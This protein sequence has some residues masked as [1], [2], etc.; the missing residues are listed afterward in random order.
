MAETHHHSASLFLALSVGIGVAACQSVPPDPEATGDPALVVLLVVDQLGE[1]L[2]ERYEDVYTGG[3]RR[4]LDDGYRFTSATHDHASTET[5][6]GHATLATGV[7]PTRHGIVGNSWS[8]RDGDGWRSEYALEELGSPVLGLPDREGRGPENIEREGLANWVLERNG[9]GKVVSVSGKDRSA[10]AMA[11]TAPGQVYWLERDAGL[12]VTAEHYRSE[13]PD[14]VADFNANDIPA[15]YG[16]T[17]WT[18]EVPEALKARSRPDTSRYEERRDPAFPHALS[19]LA[20][21]SIPD[22]VN[23]WRWTFTPFTDRAVTSFAIRAIREEQLGRR[24]PQDYLGVSLSA[25]DLVG[26]RFGPGSREQLDNLLRLDRELE[27]LFDA[28]DD[29]VG[30]GR[31]VLVMS[32]DHGVLEI[33]EELSEAGQDAGRLG[34][35]ERGDFIAALEGARFVSGDSQEAAKAAVLELPFVAAAY[36]FDE[37]ES[38]AAVDSFAVLYANAHSDTRITELGA[39]YGV[40]VRFLPSY[41]QWGANAATHGSP[42]YYDR[43]VPLIFLGAGVVAGLSGEPVATLD[44]APTLARLAGLDT[45]DDLDGRVLE[46][47]LGR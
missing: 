44:A 5:A 19:E 20:D 25:V 34:R 15:L 35:A 33:P 38:G 31:W 6:P 7:Y 45:P 23:D 41:L 22:E 40:Y 14:W 37:I 4:L 3:F 9:D 18:S 30:S 43:Q 32:S 27:R 13:V 1:D 11:T 36:T 29:E 10:I 8:V 42:Y 47:V 28:L 17:L 39:R 12:F 46:A 2:L 24:G 21:P 26:H 16:D